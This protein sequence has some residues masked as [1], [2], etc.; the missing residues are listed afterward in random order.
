MHV[1]PLAP[2]DQAEMEIDD[3]LAFA[4][5]AQ[6]QLEAEAI[7]MNAEHD[8]GSVALPVSWLPRAPPC[9]LARFVLTAWFNA[10]R[11]TCGGGPW[12]G[13]EVANGGRGA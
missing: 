5:E 10:H 2:L 6:R 3:E 1:E 13:Q 4:D 8:D 7:E 11:R 9:S 12:Q